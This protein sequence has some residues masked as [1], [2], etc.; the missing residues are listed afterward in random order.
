[1]LRV[2]WLT[3]GRGPGSFGALDYLFAAIERGLPVEV[4]VVFLNRELREAEATDRLMD[5]V[6]SKR[7]PLETLSSV[8]FRKAR[9][10]ALSRPGEPLPAWRAEFDGEVAGRL[11]RYGFDLGIMFG[12]MLIATEPLFT[13]FTFLNDHPALPEGPV[14]TWQQVI[15][16]LI[17]GRAEESGCMWNVVTGDLDR[18]PV[19]SFSRFEIAGP[20]IARLWTEALEL[21]T[22]A[23]DEDLKGT[24]LFAEIRRRGVVSERPLMVETL[25]AVAEGRLAVPPPQPADLTLD[26]ERLIRESI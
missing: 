15:L 19:V 7:V 1:V 11:A 2:A 24:R 20:D 12:Y 21:G 9:G 13:R 6:R 26:V 3:T 10:G 5:F 25:R 18:G 14:G 17:R 8:R 16:E 23:S 4:A 22:G